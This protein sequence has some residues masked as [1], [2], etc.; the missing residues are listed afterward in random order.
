MAEWWNMYRLQSMNRVITELV[1]MILQEVYAENTD[2]MLKKI[3]IN[4]EIYEEIEYY[5]LKVIYILFVK[6]EDN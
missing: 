3:K 4:R 2:E 6:S 1:C 5:I